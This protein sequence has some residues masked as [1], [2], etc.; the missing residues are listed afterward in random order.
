MLGDHDL[1]HEYDLD[2]HLASEAALV[3]HH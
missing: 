3:R 1:V 2:C